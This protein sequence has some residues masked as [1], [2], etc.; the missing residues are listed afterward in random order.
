MTSRF[1]FFPRRSLLLPDFQAEEVFLL[2]SCH[3]LWFLRINKRCQPLQSQQCTNLYDVSWFSLSG[4][5][6]HCNCEHLNT[7]ILANGRVYQAF[8]S[9]FKTMS[10]VHIRQQK[11][12]DN[13]YCHLNSTSYLATEI[14]NASNKVASLSAAGSVLSHC[15]QGG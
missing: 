8:L 15:S 4:S 9:V 12:V 13:I 3:L 10:N 1:S 7:A 5:Q 14:W 11:N 2:V 6:S